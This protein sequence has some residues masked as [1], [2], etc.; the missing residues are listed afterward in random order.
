MHQEVQDDG[1]SSTYIRKKWRSSRLQP[2]EVYEKPWIHDKEPRKIYERILFC[3]GCFAG[4]CIGGYLIYVSW[5]NVT[6]SEYCIILDDNFT[7]IDPEVWN[8]EI[9]IGG[10]G[11]GSFEWTTSDESNIY[12]DENGLHINPTLTLNT[13]TLTSDEL[14]NGAILNLTSAGTC[15]STQPNECAIYS[16]STS[17]A[18]IPPVRSARINT[19][20]KRAIKYGKVE[21]VAKFPVGD[22]IWPN[23]WMLP[24]T[25]SY[26]AWPLSGEIDIAQ[27]RGNAPGYA[28][29]RDTVQST[30]HWGPNG[31]S[32]AYWRTNGLHKIPRTDFS[33]KYHKFGLEWNPNYMF[34]Y[35][36]SRLLQVFFIKFGKGTTMWNR[37]KFG[38]NTNQSALQDPWSWT[39]RP[40]TPFDQDF[41][42]IMDVA[43]GGTDGYFPD[44]VG[45]K[46][47]VDGNQNAPLAFWNAAGTWYPTWGDG[48][49]VGLNVRSV[50]MYSLGACGT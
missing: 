41:Y 40:S 23:I 46:P 4:L 17:G 28:G 48:D 30:L 37:G 18:I 31:N 38:S 15:T 16:N 42:L 26:G 21:V 24:Q 35:L 44:G 36:D 2:G 27:S 22:W 14:F 11:K 39:G 5:T 29:G 13:T 3:M 12:V 45:N 50:K 6:N 47:W 32:D 20:N 8:Y 1:Q 34:M 9:Q 7:S 43:V 10:F 19:M 25:E 33:K 49:T